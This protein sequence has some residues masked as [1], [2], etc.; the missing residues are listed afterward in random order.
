MATALF[1]SPKITDDPTA[2]ADYRLRKRKEF[3]TLISRASRNKSVWVKYAEWEESQKDLKRAHSIWERALAVDALHHDHTIWL[4]YIDMEMKN[5]FVN[6]ARNVWDRAVTL[7]PR[8]DQLWY[9]YIHMEEM[10]GNVADK[11]RAIFK[12][13]VQC[14]PKVSAW[15][16]FAKFEMEN[17]EIERA[18]NCYERAVEKLADD[19]DVKQLLVVFPEFEDKFKKK[20]RPRKYEKKKVILKL[21]YF[22]EKIKQ[23]AMIN[24]SSL[25]GVESISINSK[26]KKL[27]IT[28]NIDPVSL[29]FK[30]R[31][32]CYTDILSVGPAKEPEKKKDEGSKKDERG[33]KEEGKKDDAKKGGRDKKKKDGKDEAQ[34][35]PA[36]MFYHYQQPYQPTVTVPAYYNYPSIEE[37]PNSCVIF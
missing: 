23:K 7:L 11:A 34:A 2:L 8:V 14:H 12:R 28:G 25:E 37:D 30:L 33:K 24:V 13:F 22:D 9:K 21:E 35:Y 26:E 3:E 4:K 31:K 15:I 16:R 32:L 36:P 18:R 10:L 27:T 6:H 19:E 29:V 1:R 17:G 20:G 5:K